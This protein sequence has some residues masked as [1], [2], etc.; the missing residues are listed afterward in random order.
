MSFDFAEFIGRHFGTFWFQSYIFF[1]RYLTSVYDWFWHLHFVIHMV[2][3]SFLLKTRDQTKIRTK[4]KVT[5][6]DKLPM[7]KKKKQYVN[8]C[9]ENLAKTF[10]FSGGLPGCES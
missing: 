8:G 5:D 3:Y 6:V 4:A 9:I 2:D 7:C 1:P 10:S